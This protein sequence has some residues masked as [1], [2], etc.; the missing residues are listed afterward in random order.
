MTSK[1]TGIVSLAA[2]E[3]FAGLHQIRR[4][5]A[6]QVQRRGVVQIISHKNFDFRLFESDLALL[7][8]DREVQITHYVKPI[9][10]PESPT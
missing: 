3:I 5:N 8:L 10:L 2:L 1:L 7:K 9:C 4:L 6:S